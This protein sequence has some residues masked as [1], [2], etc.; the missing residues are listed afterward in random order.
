MGPASRSPGD[1]GS[2]GL[3]Y[4]IL[5]PLEI[6][7]GGDVVQL[8]PPRA[9]AVLAV[10]LVHANRVVSADRLCEELWPAGPP[11]SGRSALHVHVAAL[12]RV[13]GLAATLTTRQSGY[14]VELDDDQLDV[15]R[16][17][18]AAKRGRAALA[19]GDAERARTE[20]ELALGLWRGTPLADLADVPCV[21]SEAARLEDERL[22]ALEDRI[23][24]DLRLG[25]HAELAGELAQ[26]AG[27]HP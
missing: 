25:R 9:Q 17:E 10:L 27:E 24:A 14:V 19:A 20:L 22:A 6:R 2:R 1:A 5:G 13:L 7:C 21:R 15:W 26:L 12:R 11:S 16:F 23:E 4:G 8:P 18:R 3:E